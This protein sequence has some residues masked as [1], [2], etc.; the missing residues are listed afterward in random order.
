MTVG[1]IYNVVVHVS[2][3]DLITA[4]KW[5]SQPMK[6]EVY[7]CLVSMIEPPQPGPHYMLCLG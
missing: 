3:K 4:N 2:T 5:V 6:N 7:F 1:M